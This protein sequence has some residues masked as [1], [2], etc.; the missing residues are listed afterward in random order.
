[1]PAIVNVSDFLKVSVI[2]FAFIFIVNRG[3]DKLNMSQY[4]A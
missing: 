4:K 2:A 3:L 1:M